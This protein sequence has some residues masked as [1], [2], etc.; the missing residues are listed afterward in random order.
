MG[1]FHIVNGEGISLIE[2]RELF[3]QQKKLEL[4][5]IAIQ[6]IDKCRNYLEV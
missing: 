6:Q 4:S 1:L 3:V 2:M 5:E